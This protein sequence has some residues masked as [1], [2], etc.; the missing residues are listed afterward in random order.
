MVELMAAMADMEATALVGTAVMLAEV[1][2]VTVAVAG[3]T[4]VV[5]LE[6]LKKDQ[7]INTDAG[8]ASF[9]AVAK[10]L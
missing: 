9:C 10:P 5:I 6:P 4:A 1:A 7:Q 2:E 8:C 3:A